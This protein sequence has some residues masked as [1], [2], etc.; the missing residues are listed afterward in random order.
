VQQTG[1]TGRH[2][3]KSTKQKAGPMNHKLKAVSDLFSV[4][5]VGLL[6]VVGI[7]VARNHSSA[8][9]S[10][11]AVPDPSLDEP[12]AVKPGKQ[13]AVVAGGCFW[14][15]QL[16]FQHVKGVRSATS[17]YSGGE[18]ASPEYEQVSSGNTGHAESVKIAFDP[19]QVSYG[20]LLKVFFSVAHDPTQLNRQ[21]PDV[22]TQYRSIIFYADEE[23]KR[24]AEAYVNQ[25]ERAH[26]FPGPIVTEVVPLKAFYNAEMYHQNYA[27]SHP[28]DPY[29]AINDAPKLDHL[30]D[31]LPNL[32][33]K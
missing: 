23:Q 27:T 24:I 29:I 30:R 8:T 31:Q 17:G 5:A 6:V 25:L 10:S 21:G 9:E 28:D 20:Q 33:K 3:R 12:L 32:Y 16:V 2:S 7:A 18:V 11:V 15:I 4:V 1:E 13:T 26:V 14:G 19:A 22:G